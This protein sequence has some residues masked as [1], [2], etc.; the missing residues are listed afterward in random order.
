VATISGQSNVTVQTTVNIATKTV[1][2]TKTNTVSMTVN[3][4]CIESV[5]AMHLGGY[6][7]HIIC[8]WVLDDGTDY[9]DTYTQA[10]TDCLKVGY[11]YGL[12]TG[13]ILEFSGIDHHPSSDKAMLL[14]YIKSSSCER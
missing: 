14:E 12:W 11:N 9:Y 7:D 10:Q 8:K 4:S 5:K 6:F 1:D 3:I 13:H 2:I